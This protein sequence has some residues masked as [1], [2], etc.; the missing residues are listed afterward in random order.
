MVELS[1]ATMAVGLVV[2]MTALTAMAT[3]AAMA[4]V[5][6]VEAAV[7]GGVQGAQ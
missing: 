1:A 5:A 2:P 7:E 3:V 6:T 4:E